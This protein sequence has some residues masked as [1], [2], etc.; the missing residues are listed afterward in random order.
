[1][2]PTFLPNPLQ[3]EPSAR[4]IEVSFEIT[5]Y[6]ES[7]RVEILGAAP[8]VSDAAKDELVTLIKGSRFRPR[9]KD[10]ELAGAVPV[11]L[12]YYLDDLAH[13]SADDDSAGD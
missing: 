6:G 12:R 3:T 9:V 2:L 13:N 10:G 7:R 8:E 4:Y 1:M 5:K 11:V